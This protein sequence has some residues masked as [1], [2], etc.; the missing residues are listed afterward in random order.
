[1]A[2]GDE[3]LAAAQTQLDKPYVWSASLTPDASGAPPSFDCSSLV[4]WAYS[5]VG[6]DLPRVTYDQVNAPNVSPIGLGDLAVGDLIF[7]QWNDEPPNGHVAIYAGNGQVIEAAGSD[8]GVTMT[9]FDDF[10]RSHVNN[11]R[12]V[13]GVDGSTTPGQSGLLAQLGQGVKTLAGWIPTPGNL[14]EATA[15]IGTGLAGI[16]EGAMSVGRVAQL[17]TKAFL[18]TNIIRGFCFIFGMIFILIG[19]WFL[20]REVRE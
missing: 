8:T 15:N 13:A 9:P 17:V 6:L 3:I 16:A 1:M 20:A 11:Y 14:T 12:R 10:Y 18:P 19:I 5:T 4:K 7:S 2:S